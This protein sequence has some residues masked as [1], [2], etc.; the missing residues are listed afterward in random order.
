M[1]W[2][3]HRIF[4]CLTP[5]GESMARQ[6][7]AWFFVLVGGLV[8]AWHCFERP[9]IS[10]LIRYTWVGR[11][12]FGYDLHHELTESISTPSQPWVFVYC[13]CKQGLALFSKDSKIIPKHM[14][15]CGMKFYCVSPLW[16]DLAKGFFISSCHGLVSESIARLYHQWGF[17]HYVCNWRGLQKCWRALYIIPKHVCLCEMKFYWVV[18]WLTHFV[19][20]FFAWHV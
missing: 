14:W 4:H 13:V 16:T 1:N 10:F 6:P 19:T 11:S 9:K 12:L 15:F 7:H 2:L 8:N 17:V 18:Q 5:L 3:C 20:S